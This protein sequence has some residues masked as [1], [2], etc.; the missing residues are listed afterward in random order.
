MRARDA[1]IES[2]SSFLDADTRQ[3][4]AFGYVS[5]HAPAREA[6]GRWED[7]AAYLTRLPDAVETIVVH[8][9]LVDPAAVECLRPLGPRLCFENMN[10]TKETGRLP[11]QLEEVFASFPE[12]TF[13][14]DV[15]HVWT[16]DRSLRLGDGVLEHFGDRL[17]QI[18]LSS[19]DEHAAHRPFTSDD[20][21]LYA[22]LLAQ[23]PPAPIVLESRYGP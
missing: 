7:V 21:D 10:S 22:P 14:L 2:L 19:I 9:D 17:R 18:H 12:A 13:C 5:V 23:C 20:L 6:R 8:P 16:N 3:L 4:A 15:A 1:T 11:E